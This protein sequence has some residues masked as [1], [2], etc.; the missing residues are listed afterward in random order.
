MNAQTVK[1]RDQFDEEIERLHLRGQWRFDEDVKRASSGSPPSGVPFLWKWSDV[2]AVLLEACDVMPDSLR[3]RRNVS[4]INPGL[5]SPNAT[6]TIAAGIQLVTPGEVAWGHRHTMGAIRFGIQGDED[7]YTVVDG[8]VLPLAAND[9]VLTPAWTWHDHHNEMPRNG[10]WLDVLD[11]PLLLAIDQARFEPFGETVQPQHECVE[12]FGST[13]GAT[14]RP[15]WEQRRT[16]NV[17]LRYA[18]RDVEPVLRAYGTQPASPFDD[19]LLEYVNPFTGGSTLPTI[20]CFIQLL[21]AGFEGRVHRRSAATVYHVVEGDG[22]TVCG[23]V[24][25]PWTAHDSFVVPS[26][27]SHRHI[28]ASSDS[29]AIL[30]SA[31][32]RPVLEALALYREEPDVATYLRPA[33]IAPGNRAS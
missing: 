6:S 8:D 26:W 10:V 12:H 11:V 32:D 18:W 30:F 4:F 16:V 33:P 20:G 29:A 19:V 7:L 15:A 23:D 31:T 24:E 3:Q 25:L 22:V 9:L 1:S 21:R 13:R 14:V 5:R 2:D 17:P 27:M 28:N